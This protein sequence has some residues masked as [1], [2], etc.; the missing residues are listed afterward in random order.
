MKKCILIV[1]I[2]IIGIL[3]LSSIWLMIIVI[4]N[5]KENAYI[6]HV[7]VW[8]YNSTSYQ[9]VLEISDTENLT[10]I[11]IYNHTEDGNLKIIEVTYYAPHYKDGEM[12]KK[13]L[14]KYP[15]IESIGLYKPR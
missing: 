7:D 14:E 6:G 10:I 1:I 11:E 9:R 4:K 13:R 2:C 3:I 15:E 12:V 8:Y 5:T